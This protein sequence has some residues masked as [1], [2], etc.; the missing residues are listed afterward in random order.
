M[1]AQSKGELVWDSQSYPLTLL[2]TIRFW[3]ISIYTDRW[4][5]RNIYQYISFSI[6]FF[7]GGGGG[8][9]NASETCPL[10]F[11]WIVD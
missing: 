9:G 3:H 7:L 1:I 4:I 2:N 10:V 5:E 8:F 6:L 11:T